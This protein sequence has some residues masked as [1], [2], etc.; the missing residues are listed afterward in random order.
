MGSRGLFLPCGVSRPL[1]VP[2]HSPAAPR[3]FPPP[4]RRLHALL[5][6]SASPRYRRAARPFRCR[7]RVPLRRPGASRRHRVPFLCPPVAAR[8]PW[9]VPTA[10]SRRPRVPVSVS[11]SLLGLPSPRR[12]PV[13]SLRLRPRVLSACRVSGGVPAYLRR[14]LSSPSPRAPSPRCLSVFLA[15]TASPVLSFAARP[16]S[17]VSTCSAGRRRNVCGGSRTRRSGCDRPW[18]VRANLGGEGRGAGRAC[19]RADEGCGCLIWGLWG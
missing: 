9:T 19:P 2:F 10:P 15:V 6:V 5:G 3:P 18:M 16:V 13:A 7:R 1:G 17:A 4:P 8:V 12:A 11:A 14:I